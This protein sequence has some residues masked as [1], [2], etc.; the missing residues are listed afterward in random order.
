MYVCKNRFMEN[1]KQKLEE[2]VVAYG[3]KVRMGDLVPEPMENMEEVLRSRGY[4]S[5][6]EFVERLSKYL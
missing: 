1:K 2:P 6:E 5:H 4:I 3:R